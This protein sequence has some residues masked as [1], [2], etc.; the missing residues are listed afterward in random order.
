M[1]LETGT[2]N[3]KFTYQFLNR[4]L[5]SNDNALQKWTQS[6]NWGSGAE[7]QDL[8]DN[9]NFTPKFKSQVDGQAKKQP[10]NFS[11]DSA[12]LHEDCRYQ[13]WGQN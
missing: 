6:Q 7:S 13:G 12:W 4:Y 3:F 2:T 8:R 9:A 1:Y 5:K 11:W 10:V